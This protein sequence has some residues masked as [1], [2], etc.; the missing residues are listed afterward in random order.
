MAAA[1]FIPPSPHDSHLNMATSTRRQPLMSISNA[2]NSP[3]RNHLTNSGSKRTRAAASISQQENEPPTKR[4]ALEKSAHESVPVT[5]RRYNQQDNGEGRLFDRP[6]RDPLNTFQKKLVAARD[7]D[8][9]ARTTRTTTHNSKDV[10]NVRQWQKHYRKLFPQFT[11]YFDSIPDDQKARF[12]KQVQYLGAVS[13]PCCCYRGLYTNNDVSTK[14]SSFLTRS[15]TSSPLD[16]YHLLML[17][18]KLL[19][20][21]PRPL[22]LRCLRSRMAKL[23]PSDAMSS[24]PMIFCFG[25]HKW[26]SRYGQLRSSKESLRP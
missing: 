2:T 14:K 24:T 25:H 21:T 11:F 8:G 7:R 15:L 19:P 13:L 23:P 20:R 5:P 16:P 10:E 4:Q 3:H 22:T 6:T 18:P 1:V 17:S 12:G 9:H 26:T